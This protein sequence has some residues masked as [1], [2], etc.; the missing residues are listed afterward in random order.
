MGDR[1]SPT[2]TCE[3]FR[4]YFRTIFIK[5]PVKVHRSPGWGRLHLRLALCGCLLEIV[6]YNVGVRYFYM[7]AFST[8]VPFYRVNNV[9]AGELV[10]LQTITNVLNFLKVQIID[11]A[12]VKRVVISQWLNFLPKRTVEKVKEMLGEIVVSSYERAKEQQR[13]EG[14]IKLERGF[15]TFISPALMYPSSL[16]TFGPALCHSEHVI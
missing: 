3:F 1:G 6:N 7:V 15:A 13:N 10:A 11:I 14:Y 5:T 16:A 4:P 12:K 2:S 8:N 9:C